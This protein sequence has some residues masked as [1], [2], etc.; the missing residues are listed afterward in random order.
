MSTSGQIMNYPLSFSSTAQHLVKDKRKLN[1]N[2]R[3]EAF[4]IEEEEIQV[5]FCQKITK[6]T[7]KS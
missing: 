1:I 4:K 6:K 7:S 2:Q 3:T 5:Q